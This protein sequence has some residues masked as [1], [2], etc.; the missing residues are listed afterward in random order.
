MSG[1]A[2]WRSSSAA[3]AERRGMAKLGALKGKRVLVTGGCGFLGRHIVEALLGCGAE[4]V[5][6]DIVVREE[7]DRRVRFVAGDLM[8]EEALGEALR[9]CW[10][11]MHV[12]SPSPLCNNEALFMRVNV[13]GS[14]N[15]VRLARRA[16][17][18]K[19]VYTSSA[20]V[21]FD[22]TDQMAFSEDTPVP[23]LPMDAYTRSKRMG[24]Q[25]VLGESDDAMPV[26]ALRPH[27]I[28]GPR[29]PH[30]VPALARAGAAGKS[31]YMIGDG[32]NLV[33]F[34]YVGNVAYAHLLAAVQLEAG[35]PAAGNAYFITNRDPVLFW[36][37]LTDIQRYLGHPLPRL[38]VPSAVMMPMARAAEAAAKVVPFTPTFTKQSV[39]YAARHHYYQS[40]RAAADLGYQPVVPMDEAVRRTCES[41]AAL[42]R[43]EA[44]QRERAR[45]ALGETAPVLRATT[46]PA[47]FTPGTLALPAIVALLLV[48]GHAKV[49]AAVGA[50]FVYNLYRRVFGHAVVRFTADVDLSGTL[51]VVTGGNKGIGRATA[52]GLARRG[53][54]VVLACRN[55]ELGRRAAEEVG[56]EAGAAG[57]VS[58]EPLDL[59]SFS[60]VRAFVAALVKRH[61]RGSLGLLVNNAG[62]MIAKGTTE[63]GNDAQFQVNHLGPF[64]LTTWLLD[65]GAAGPSMRVVNVSS[66]AHRGGVLNFDD[67]NM[68]R[69][70]TRWGAYETTKLCNVIFSNELHRRLGHAATAEARMCSIAVHPGSVDTDFVNHFLP[71]CVARVVRPALRTM[72]T[73][74]AEE[75]AETVLYAAIHPDMRTVG[76]QYIVNSGIARADPITRDTYVAARL[77]RVSEEMLPK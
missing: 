43:P 32:C 52:L 77:W 49:A 39:T 65:A 25:A 4:V 33:D 60:S 59:A 1:S 41:F 67:L 44:E 20:S 2:E 24:E 76:A 47:G 71:D 62:A 69:S 7:Y 35:S 17:V 29:D 66:M 26:C 37:M 38:S 70:Y 45:K 68:E 28:F 23:S 53:A 56:R 46:R 5:V 36:D 10:A 12:A 64:A 34:T 40:E 72:F 27:G 57:R 8:D 22:G 50:L 55:P 11:V 54:T 61:G 14:L 6:F 42:R 19:V 51:A 74:T 21:V 13:Q 9:G 58:F 3:E 75:S 30:L 48:L 18:R 16:G 63:D 15:V 73:I 31:K